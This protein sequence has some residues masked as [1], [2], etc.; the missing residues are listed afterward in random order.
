MTTIEFINKS[1]II[2]NNKYSYDNTIFTKTSEKTIITCPTHGDFYQVANSHLRGHGCKKCS[3]STNHN[4]ELHK[5]TFLSKAKAKFPELNFDSIVWVSTTTP[6][7]VQCLIHGPFTI[8]PNALLHKNCKGCPQLFRQFY[9]F[10]YFGENVLHRKGNSELLTSNILEDLIPS[11]ETIENTEE[12]KAL[13]G[14]E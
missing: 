6:I 5:Q 2:H 10:K 4:M 11:V 1:S 14:S 9:K 12:F 3:D 7:E 13:T 8:G